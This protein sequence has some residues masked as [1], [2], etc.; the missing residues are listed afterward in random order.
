MIGMINI[1]TKGGRIPY[2]RLVSIVPGHT[3]LEYRPWEQKGGQQFISIQYT[4]SLPLCQLIK[5][6]HK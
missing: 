5:E 1:H 6:K 4:L 3:T 2:V